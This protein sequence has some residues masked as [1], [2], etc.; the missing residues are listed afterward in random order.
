MERVSYVVIP[1]LLGSLRYRLC[2]RVVSSSM[3]II[4]GISFLRYFDPCIS[5]RDGTLK[6]HDGARNWM[7][8]LCFV[9]NATH[10]ADGWSVVVGAPEAPDNDVADILALTAPIHHSVREGAELPVMAGEGSGIVQGPIPPII[11]RR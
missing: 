6:I 4:L 3:G 11:S 8:P 10:S 2:L 7:V 5:W 9:D 1:A